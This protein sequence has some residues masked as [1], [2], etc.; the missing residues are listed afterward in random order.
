MRSTRPP[1]SLRESS[2]PPTPSSTAYPDQAEEAVRHLTDVICALPK[3][4]AGTHEVLHRLGSTVV[5]VGGRGGSGAQAVWRCCSRAAF[6]RGRPWPAIAAVKPRPGGSRSRSGP[7]DGPRV[8]FADDH[9][10]VLTGGWAGGRQRRGGEQCA[11]GAPVGLVSAEGAVWL[12][13]ARAD[14]RP[15]A[16]AVVLLCGRLCCPAGQVGARPAAGE[17]GHRDERL[18]AVEAVGSA[19][20]HPQVGVGGLGPGVWT[21]HR[22]RGC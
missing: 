9:R 5:S 3:N 19:G 6:V 1:M 17:H 7:G 11:E 18:G 16:L 15:A 12:A 21:G 8:A 10:V 2:R 22:R 14:G 13:C 20:Q 4:L